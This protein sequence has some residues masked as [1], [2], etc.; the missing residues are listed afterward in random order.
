MEEILIAVLL[1]GI[2]L[3]A[4]LKI[5]EW[6]SEFQKRNDKIYED[7]INKRLKK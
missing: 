2:F 7:E 6:L 5:S 4:S 3:L 1:V